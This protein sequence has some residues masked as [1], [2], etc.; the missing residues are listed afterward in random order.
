MSKK[1]G[2]AGNGLLHLFRVSFVF[3]FKNKFLSFFDK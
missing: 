1:S 3:V 2:K